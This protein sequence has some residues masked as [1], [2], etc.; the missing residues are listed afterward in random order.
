MLRSSLA[1]LGYIY[2]VEP[3][4]GEREWERKTSRRQ[5]QYQGVTHCLGVGHAEVTENLG[6]R[7]NVAETRRPDRYHL[8]GGHGVGVRGYRGHELGEQEVLAYANPQ[9]T[10]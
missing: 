8:E 3:L 9:S 6:R 4:H 7:R 10:R 1:L 2:E 5:S